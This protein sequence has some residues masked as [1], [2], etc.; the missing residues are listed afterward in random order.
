[1]VD[2]DEWIRACIPDSETDEALLRM[3]NGIAVP[4]NLESS[5]PYEI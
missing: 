4:E 3:N 2:G 1:M 5:L